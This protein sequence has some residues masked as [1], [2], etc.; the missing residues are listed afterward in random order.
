MGANSK[1]HLTFSYIKSLPIDDEPTYF[2]S[3]EE[4]LALV[5]KHFPG[6]ILPNPKETITDIG[7]DESLTQIAFYGIGQVY[8]QRT[9]DRDRDTYQV[10]LTSL[11]S[12]E[13]REGYEL[14]G[15]RAVF[16]S[17]GTPLEIFVSSMA[18][19]V[20]PGQADWEHAKRVWMSSL[21]LKITLAAHLVDLHFTVSN[22]A[23]IA[24]RTILNKDH[25]I[26]RV[27]KIFLFNTGQV[28]LGGYYF[29][30]EED[31]LLH[32]MSGVTFKSITSAFRLSFE[33][34]KFS[35]FPDFLHDKDLGEDVKARIPIYNDALL[36]WRA[37]H[38]FFSSY[39]NFF[40]KDHEDILVDGEL[41][42]FWECVDLRGNMGSSSRYGLPQLSRESLINYLT[43][44]AFTV[45]AWHELVGT[46]I[47]YVLPPAKGIGIKIRPG[48][49][50][51]DVQ[52]VV[53]QLSSVALTGMVNPMIMSNWKHL[54]PE[55][56]EVHQ[57]HDQLMDDL[58]KIVEK[59]DALNATVPNASRPYRCQTFNPKYHETS[60]SL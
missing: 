14:P 48:R 13:P 38:S 9:P 60:V 2:E 11:S 31:M 22:C 58:K 37:Y 10:D 34:F 54:L 51:S 53:E 25:P 59:V 50:R 23:H 18:K 1:Q 12:M 19:V 41:G 49:E 33:E 26:R 56:P 39:V 32:R 15:A 21:L 47:Q 20:E 30:A 5:K 4:A 42:D 36:N 27:L 46:V 24:T 7:S 35:T 28:N 52:A 44:V 55:H 3:D 57:F 40:Y 43:H 16:S 6:D 29:L 8:L 17:D 45:T